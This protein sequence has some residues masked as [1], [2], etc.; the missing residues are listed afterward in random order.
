MAYKMKQVFHVLLFFVCTC[1]VIAQSLLKVTPVEDTPKGFDRLFSKQVDIFG[2]VIFATRRTPDEK[3]LHAAGVLAQYLDNDSDGYPDNELVIQAIHKSKGAMVMFATE[4]AAEKIDVHRY[5]PEKVWD[6]MTVLGL[7]AEETHPGGATRGVFDAT[8]EEVLHLITS[9][10][11]ANAYP[12]IFGEKPDTA[13][14]K[15]L[16]KARGGTFEEFLGNIQTARGSCTTTEPV[17]TPARS[18]NTFIGALLLFLVLR[19]FPDVRR[20]SPRNGD[21]TLLL[22]LRME[23][24]RFTSY[25]Q[26][27]SILFQPSSRM[28]NTI[29]GNGIRLGLT[30][31]R[32]TNC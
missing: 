16:D 2:V 6:S 17:T 7:Y 31:P 5:I 11:Y 22:R 24:Q 28:G 10:G 9:A 29:L 27:P 15:A 19:I 32:Q 26:P 1:T 3:L 13:I 23:I 21:S 20:T 30:N 25:L 14:A 12:D 18:L 4:R 8:Y